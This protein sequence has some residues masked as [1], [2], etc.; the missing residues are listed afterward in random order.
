M[1]E[2]RLF[3]STKTVQV[4][5]YTSLCDRLSTVSMAKMASF[6]QSEIAWLTPQQSGTL[7]HDWSTISQ[8]PN[9]LEFL[10]AHSGR[11][12][13]LTGRTSK[14]VCHNVFGDHKALLVTGCQ[15][16]LENLIVAVNRGALHH[17]I[18]PLHHAIDHT[19]QSLLDAGLVHAP[20]GY[21]TQ[22]DIV[23]LHNNICARGDAHILTGMEEIDHA[24]MFLNI[25]SMGFGSNPCWQ[26]GLLTR[27]DGEDQVSLHMLTHHQDKV[28]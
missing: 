14:L 5:T 9:G 11:S 10:G 15:A 12:H 22:E 18:C 6:E 28:A 27:K 19:V 17:S 13:D 2:I 24:L 8:I 20:I 3:C 7:N 16:H 21:A 1:V 23:M 25:S 4:L 26:V